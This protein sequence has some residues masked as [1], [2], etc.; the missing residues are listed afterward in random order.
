VPVFFVMD[1][2]VDDDVDDDDDD[3]F[4][5]LLTSFIIPF[6]KRLFSRIVPSLTTVTLRTVSTD[7]S[8][9]KRNVFSRSYCYTV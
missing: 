5:L 9:L 2:D 7:N 4:S 8:L 6:S 1:N 3:L